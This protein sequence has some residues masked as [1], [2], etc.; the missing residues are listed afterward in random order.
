MDRLNKRFNLNIIPY[1]NDDPI[2]KLTIKNDV[3][4]IGGADNEQIHNND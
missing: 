1:Y 3:D 2:S 4:G